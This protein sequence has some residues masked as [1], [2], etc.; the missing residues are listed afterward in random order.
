MESQWSNK[1]DVFWNNQCKHWSL[2]FVN[3]ENYSADFEDL[4]QAKIIISSC[5][6]FLANPKNEQTRDDYRELAE[7]TII[8]LGGTP[9]RVIHFMA[10]GAM[11]NACWIAKAIYILKNS[12]EW[13][14][15]EQDVL[16]LS[17]REKK[18]LREVCHFIIEFYSDYWFKCTL[19]IKAPAADLNLLQKLALKDSSTSNAALEKLKNHLCYLS[20]ELIA[21]SFFDNDV[22]CKM[23][24][25]N[26]GKLE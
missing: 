3:Q 14:F 12:S 6:D 21:L 24:K 4:P 18:G 9:K 15:R 20:E 2:S 19:P 8:S 23:K 22:D 26:G 13:L 11:H 25:K 17:Q 1:G 5:Q 10:P 7:L 16:K